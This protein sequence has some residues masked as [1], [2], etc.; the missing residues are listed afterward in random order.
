MQSKKKINKSTILNQS[1]S[2]EKIKQY[3]HERK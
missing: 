3:T 2:E 1:K